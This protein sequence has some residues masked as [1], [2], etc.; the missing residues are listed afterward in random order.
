MAILKVARLGTPILREVAAAIPVDDIPSADIQSLIDDMLETMRDYCG[1]GLAAPQVHRGLRLVVFEVG[2]N[3]RY[4]D[5]T[6]VPL[7]I[8]INPEI[9]IL[10][11]TPMG[12]WEGCLSVPGL[13]GYVERPGRIKLSAMDRKG[14]PFTMVLDGFAATVAQHE[15][16]HLDG[17]VYLDAMQNNATL[18][19][20]EE[21]SRYDII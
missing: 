7:T 19:F 17:K 9:T 10:D 2:S 11:S 12:C 3:P 14:Q 13:R 21:L 20:V 4:P 5:A 8:A 16:D 15:C 1:A 6:P 18:G